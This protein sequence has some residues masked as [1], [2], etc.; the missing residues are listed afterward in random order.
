[1][2]T[3]LAI[4]VLTALVVILVATALFGRLALMIGQPRVFGEMAAGVVLGPSVAGALLP[5]TQQLFPD[6]VRSVLYVLSVIGLTFFMFLVGCGI[7]HDHVDRGTVRGS[8]AIASGGLLLPMA[9][10]ALTAVVF[11]DELAVPGSDTVAFTMF[12][13]GALSV[14]AFPMLARILRER[15]IQDTRIGT[16]ITMA[17][18]I[19]DAVA[20]TLLALVIALGAAGATSS[21]VVAVA[22]L[23]GLTLVMLTA[24]RRALGVL[25]RNTERRGHL[26]PGGMVVI[27]LVVLASGSVSELVGVHAIFGGFLAGLAIPRS[28][29]LRA[30]IQ[31]RLGDMSSLLLLPVF[32]AFSGLNTQLGTLIDVSLLLP[33]AVILA[34]A[35][36]GKYLGCGLAVRGLGMSWRHA[37]AVGG[38]MN[39]RGLIILIFI[40]VGLAH[41]LV[42]PQLFSILV[43]VAVVTTAAAMP[44]YRV[45][46]PTWLENVE[47]TASG[48]G[49]APDPA[50]T[51]TRRA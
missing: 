51:P 34:V 44:I 19:D 39:A 22:G 25:A 43:V 30:Q 9:L 41:G 37:S 7:N 20:W 48:P 29:V 33:T 4:G 40:N 1:M 38:L 50:T 27:L 21:A 28:T 13:G 45:S 32:F 47:L 18:A 49:G 31:S 14:T 6:D 2:E 17:A 5:A 8:I 36:A 11:F 23:A 24:V 16:L 3:T 12:L 42:T 15:G 46:F 10:G 35:F 26:E